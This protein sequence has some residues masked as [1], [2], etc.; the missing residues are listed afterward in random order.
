MNKIIR[1]K[2]ENYTIVSNVC[3]RDNRLSLKAKGLMSLVMSLPNDWDFSIQGLSLIVKEG[4]S[5][6]YTAINE[7]KDF[8]Y[9]Q[10]VSNRDDKGK[11][12]GNDYTFFEEPCADVPYTDVPY[13]ENQD[14][15]NPNMDNQDLENQPQINKDIKEIKNETIKEKEDTNVSLKKKTIE[16][17]QNDFYN[18]LIPYVSVYGKE[19][20]R[21]FYDYWT[22]PNKSKTKMRFQIEKTWDVSRRL[23]RWEKNN[24]KQFNNNNY[25]RPKT[26]SDKFIDSVREANDFA[27]QLR[28]N[29]GKQTD[30]GYGDSEEVW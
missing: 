8:G 7:L 24:N 30:M 13:T 5:A 3:I 1:K 14:M 4:K 28:A 15:D 21:A 23:A 29:I 9:C 27:A 11:I 20:V 26:N 19:M 2:N 6:I 18:S 10:V 25:G 17:A 12:I 22:E 16:D